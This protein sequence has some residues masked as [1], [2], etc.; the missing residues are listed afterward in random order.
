MEQVLSNDMLNEIYYH[1]DYITKCILKFVNKMYYNK[2]FKVNIRK[3]INMLNN[4]LLPDK[5]GLP[6]FCWKK[7]IQTHFQMKYINDEHPDASKYIRAL[8]SREVDNLCDEVKSFYVERSSSG[9]LSRFTVC[10]FDYNKLINKMEDDECCEFVT[11]Y[12]NIDFIKVDYYCT[13]IYYNSND[14]IIDNDNINFDYSKNRYPVYKEEISS[15]MDDQYHFNNKI[16]KYGDIIFKNPNYDPLRWRMKRLYGQYSFHRNGNILYDKC[17]DKYIRLEPI[18]KKFF[19]DCIS[20]V[21]I[22]DINIHYFKIPILFGIHLSGNS[23]TLTSHHVKILFNNYPVQKY[24]SI[25]YH[26]WAKYKTWIGKI[27]NGNIILYEVSL[28]TSYYNDDSVTFKINPKKIKM[29]S[30]DALLI[31]PIKGILNLS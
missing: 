8:C 6:S 28:T 7:V 31:Y 30:L 27:H 20:S 10:E 18:I 16:D 21:S 23:V 9:E 2:S 26:E 14:T 11:Q 3:I 5:N 4:D 24:R 17:Y 13:W 22:Y 19:D 29:R 1:S 25:K 15:Y 12:P